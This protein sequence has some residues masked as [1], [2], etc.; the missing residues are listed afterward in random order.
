MANH[1][2]D[3]ADFSDTSL[4]ERKENDLFTKLMIAH[5]VA[6]IA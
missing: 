5:T 6:E 4:I 2:R 1:T 3:G